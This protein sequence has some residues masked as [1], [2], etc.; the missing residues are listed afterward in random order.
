MQEETNKYMK[1]FYKISP[2]F[3]AGLVIMCET[4]F[5]FPT[6]KATY[7]LVGAMFVYL[8]QD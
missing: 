7:L 5:E 2:V 8:I 3:M 4:F 1:E 6:E